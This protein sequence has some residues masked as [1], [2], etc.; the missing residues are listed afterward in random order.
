MVG[1]RQRLLLA[2]VLA[3]SC[4]R[5]GPTAEAIYAKAEAAIADERFEEALAL[6]PSDA[7]LREMRASERLRER[8]RVLQGEM[9]AQRPD[10]A[11]GLALLAEPLRPE[12]DGELDRRRRR[13][14]G[15]GRCRTARTAEE[16]AAGVAILNEVL[17]EAPGRSA[18]AAAIQLRRGV[19]LRAIGEYEKAESAF[20]TGFAA[21]GAA[22]DRLAEAQLSA[23]LGSLYASRERFDEAAAYTQ[24]ALRLAGEAGPAGRHLRRRSLDNLG[25]H[26]YE[27]GD[28]ERALD[29]L[30]K[31]EPVH[32][33]ERVV[34][35]NN[36]ARTLMA[37][38]DLG[39]AQMHF[40]RALTAA[41]G[42]SNV[43]A[44]DHVAVLQGLAAVAYRQQKWFEAARWNREGQELARKLG[45]GEL[46]RT[47]ELIQA[48][49]LLAQGDGDGAAPLLQRL[50]AGSGLTRE[51]RWSAH[52]EMGRLHG[53][54][55]KTKEAEA[56]LQ[57]AMRLVEEGQQRLTEAEDRISFLSGR[58]DVYRETLQLLL[59]QNR[60]DDALRVAERSRARTM[61]TEKTKAAARR[62]GTTLFYWLDEPASHVWATA[63]GGRTVY[64]RLPGA[65]EIDDLVERHNQFVQRARDPL[66]D[67]GREARQLYE[68][69]VQPVA[70]EL[71]ER[72]VQISPDGG[73]HA[74]NFETLVAPG[75]D[76]YWLED[77]E[78]SVVPDRS[79]AGGSGA[80]RG[81]GVALAGDALD[82]GDGLPALRHAGAELEQLSAQ[83]EA[84]AL[85]KEKA[86]PGA[87]KELLARNPAYVHFA[88]HAV[89]NRLRPLESA[90]LL[91][92]EGAGHKL[93]ARDV[94]GMR[95]GSELVTLSAC[96]AAGAKAFRGEGL[97]G[98]AWAFLG[99]GAENVVA[100][101]WAVDDASTP[102]LMGQMYRQIQLGRPPAE[103]LREAKLALLRSGSALR[104][105]YFWGA[106]VHFQR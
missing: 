41:R 101:L 68:I 16:R 27:L 93:Y 90:I 60:T 81:Q 32:A 105:P 18:E 65:R 91:S 53:S 8:F 20:R 14:L 24:R 87:V 96:T 66:T 100:S 61:R 54:R 17:E 97:V 75:P 43:N 9:L 11:A 15:Y 104:K 69:L 29:T 73:L 37:M 5:P 70:G 6:I 10:P 95:L 72:R 74:L 106:F 94:V 34:N 47:G 1:R 103:A 80:R 98:F 33:R 82:G 77:V 71:T 56:E 23:S 19:C 92:P 83:F 44:S 50:L 57:R 25:W 88:A 22:G 84:P 21:A 2:A 58:M 7:V 4:S 39:G 3:V 63:P 55:G 28:Y 38:G 86:T 13:S 99:A 48:R 102:R 30:R 36:Q 40:E 79:G 89:T 67:G 52:V 62:A 51:Q 85:R 26:Q 12:A 49:I 78:I 46:E 42:N 59:R 76:H 35:E 64:R 31:F 45:Q